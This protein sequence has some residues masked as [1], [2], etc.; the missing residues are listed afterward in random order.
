MLHSASP[1]LTFPP[2]PPHPRVSSS[3]VATGAEQVYHYSFQPKPNEISHSFPD[4]ITQ[5]RAEP[6]TESPSDLHL[7]HSAYMHKSTPGQ[8]QPEV[9]VSQVKPSY[10]LPHLI[11]SAIYSSE[12]LIFHPLP[13]IAAVASQV[14]SCEQNT[15]NRKEENR[16]EQIKQSKLQ[17]PPHLVTHHTA[18]SIIKDHHNTENISSSF[19]PLIHQGG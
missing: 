9:K 3:S 14:N 11:P 16:V 2:S 10:L 12:S 13:F 17:P 6:R 18:A 19:S 8:P 7:R 4:H 5:E 1:H 15:H